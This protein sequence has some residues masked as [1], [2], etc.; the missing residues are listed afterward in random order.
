MTLQLDAR[1]RAMLHEMGVRM[2]T[3]PASSTAPL[4]L[5]AQAPAARVQTS[6][7][8]A[9]GPAPTPAHRMPAQP[10]NT[11][12]RVA[13]VSAWT[14]QAPRLLYPQAD[15]S[16]APLALGAGWLVVAEAFAP[17]DPLAEGAERLLHAM[18]HAL[19]L[20]RHPRVGLCSVSAG[21]EPGA[22]A[23]D[24]AMAEHVAAFAPAVVLVMGRSAMQ[25]ALGRREPLGKL[26]GETL[27]LAGVPV[28]VTFDARFLLRNAASKSVAWA[29]L[30]RARALA[31]RSSA[32]APVP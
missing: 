9:T 8:A 19:Q 3:P 2:W 26:R 12:E 20:H 7:K 22:Q 4:P 18:L 5:L 21:A 14:I 1:Q 15:P 27:A 13:A 17:D 24:A 23:A 29:D 28:V 30:C 16:Q 32:N 25:A 31:G 11:I 6:P 10:A